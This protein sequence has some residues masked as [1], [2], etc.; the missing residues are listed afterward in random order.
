MCTIVYTIVHSNFVNCLIFIG[1]CFLAQQLASIEQHGQKLKILHLTTF[2]TMNTFATPKIASLFIAFVCLLPLTSIA[3]GAA[4]P[5]NLKAN[6]AKTIEAAELAIE[7]D[8]YSHWDVMPEETVLS[9][10][11]PEPLY[12]NDPWNQPVET[13][14][15]YNQANELVYEVSYEPGH[16][17]SNPVTSDWIDRSDLI[18]A[19][20]GLSIYVLQ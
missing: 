17:L 10:V 1:L 15:I 4:G 18:M 20:K 5:L 19:T 7:F 12:M 3:A 2:S 16:A 9:D 14:R 13:I 6:P 11:M 8:S